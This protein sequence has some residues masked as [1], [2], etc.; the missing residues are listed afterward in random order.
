MPPFAA[1]VTNT[2]QPNL[3]MLNPAIEDILDKL[4]PMEGG[5][6]PHVVAH[7]RGGR[8]MRLLCEVYTHCSALP[9]TDCP[10]PHGPRLPRQGGLSPGPLQQWDW[11]CSRHLSLPR[12]ADTR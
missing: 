12:D 3:T 5:C 7:R 9:W 6:T 4:E 11:P 2:F 1:D 8:G 10:A